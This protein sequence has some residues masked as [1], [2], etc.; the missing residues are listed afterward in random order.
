M[1]NL[2]EGVVNVSII[3]VIPYISVPVWTLIKTESEPFYAKVAN[4]WPIFP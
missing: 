1:L 2:V 4:I 3:I